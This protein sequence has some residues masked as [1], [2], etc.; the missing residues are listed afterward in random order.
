[1]DWAQVTLGFIFGYFL[2]RFVSGGRAGVQGFWKSCKVK[3]LKR[4][5][6]YLIL[7]IHHYMASGFLIISLV[8]LL[9][10]YSGIL[11]G[12]LLGNFTQGIFYK[13]FYKILYWE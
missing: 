4:E 9:H 10:F 5:G 7:H 12:F 8:F 13:D 6:K 2:T 1:M 3:I 11:L